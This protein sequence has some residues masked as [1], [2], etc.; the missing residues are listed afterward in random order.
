M[1]NK[2]VLYLLLFIPSIV[3]ATPLGGPD[4]LPLWARYL[5]LLGWILVASVG[6]SV[7]VA[8]AIKLFDWFSTDI[9]EWEEIKQKN[10]GFTLIIGLLI[11]MIGLIV[12]A[13]ILNVFD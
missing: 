2:L 8:L 6:F 10:W 9:D 12:I 11:F 7:G 3:R 13:I 4:Q 1:L 5:E